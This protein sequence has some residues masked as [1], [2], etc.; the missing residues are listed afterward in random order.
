MKK[1]RAKHWYIILAIVSVGFLFWWF[2]VRPSNIRRLCANVAIT[3]AME[4][5][6]NIGRY[7]PADYENYFRR[8]LNEKGLK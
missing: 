1:L 4:N 3:K 7:N 2:Q 8:C 5:N 6:G